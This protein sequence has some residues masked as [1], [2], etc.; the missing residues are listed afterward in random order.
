MPWLAGTALLHS[1]LVLKKRAAQK[2]WTV[3]LSIV[4]FSLSLLGTFL[5]RSGILTSVHSFATDSRR[6]ITI[7]FILA[8]FIGCALL[9]FTFAAPSIG[10]SGL[11]SGRYRASGAGF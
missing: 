9:L 5:I 1:A 6:G 10:N 2:I 11:C 3:L 8:F 4:T 7:L